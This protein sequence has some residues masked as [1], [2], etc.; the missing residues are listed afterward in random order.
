[1][2]NKGLIA[3]SALTV[4]LAGPAVAQ[5]E[6]ARA[7]YFSVLGTYSQFDDNRN[8]PGTDIDD[9]AGIHLILGQQRASGFGLELSLAADVIETGADNGTDFYRAALGLDLIYGLGDREGFTPFA[10]IG[11]GAAY[12]DVFPDSQDDYDWFANAGLGLVTGPLNKYGAKLRF[13]VRY[14]YDAFQDSYDDYKAGLGVE[15]PLYGEPQVIEKVVE[16]VKIVE[17]AGAGGLSDSDGDGIVDDKDQCPNTPAGTR[18]DGNGCPLGDTVTLH[19][20]TFE[21]DSN[22]LRPDA[23]TILNDVYLI[24]DRY[25][26][27]IVE[28]AGHTDSIGPDAYN[29]DLSQRRAQAVLDYLADKGVDANR[30]TAVGYGESEPVDS[31]DSKEGRERNRRVELRIKN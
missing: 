13:E 8:V 4:A 23:Q 2:S 14:I 6:E 12:N 24:M 16:Q 11:A 26:E 9:G 7:T 28:V 17:V 10:L 29:Q 27:M 31:N 1:M 25:P 30:M 3:A 22:R 19:G 15:F 18:V 20:V 5:D 21:T